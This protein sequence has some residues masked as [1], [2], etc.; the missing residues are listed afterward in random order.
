VVDQ[1]VA[2]VAG[3][4]GHLFEQDEFEMVSEVGWRC[5]GAGKGA[6]L[7]EL[8]LLPPADAPP[9]TP[10]CTPP[11]PTASHM[12]VA[13]GAR[14]GSVVTRGCGWLWRRCCGSRALVANR[15]RALHKFL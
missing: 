10:L 4:C 1:E 7:I 15:V 11:T 14:V 12:T 9:R 5:R 2:V 6:A 8:P 13:A 3:P